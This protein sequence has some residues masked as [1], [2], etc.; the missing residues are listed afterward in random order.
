RE[1][2]MNIELRQDSLGVV[3]HRGSRDREAVGNRRRAESLRKEAQDLPLARRERLLALRCG[4][5][6][7]PPRPSGLPR[8]GLAAI[9]DLRPGSKLLFLSRHPWPPASKLREGAG[10]PVMQM[11]Q[12]PIGRR[13][14]ARRLLDE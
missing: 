3:A 7:S 14:A 12:G 4:E 1:A 6:R 10:R 5:R 2:R 13:T 8:G 11:D 9:S